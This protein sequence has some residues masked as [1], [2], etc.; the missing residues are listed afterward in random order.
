[1]SDFIESLPEDARPVMS[2][3]LAFTTLSRYAKEHRTLCDAPDC[4]VMDRVRRA[5]QDSLR[6]LLQK[7]GKIDAL[8]EMIDDASAL[9]DATL[10]EEGLLEA[11]T[12]IVTFPQT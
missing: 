3:V 7:V 12:M 8:A 6:D 2:A 1:M 10:L 4:P 9:L 11:S 5:R